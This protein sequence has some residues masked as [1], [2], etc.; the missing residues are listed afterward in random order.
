MF[1]GIEAVGVDEL[2]MRPDALSEP[3]DRLIQKIMKR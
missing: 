1:R 3:L 2:A